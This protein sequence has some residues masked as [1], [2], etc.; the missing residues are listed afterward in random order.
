MILLCCFYSVHAKSLQSCLTLCNPMDCSPPSLSAQEILQAR[1]LESVAMPSSRGS[2]QPRDR[3]AFTLKVKV[4][5][6]CLTLCD[7]MDYIVHG[8]LQARILKWIDS[9]LLQEIFPTQ[10]SNQGL[11]H[12]RWIL[13]QLSHKG[14]PIYLRES[15]GDAH[16]LVLLHTE[17]WNLFPMKASV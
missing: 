17:R 4:S 10:G 15:R 16:P 7:S 2:S 11:L 9:S 6:S 3:S 1:I 8:I 14:S 5:Q 13:Y 12:C